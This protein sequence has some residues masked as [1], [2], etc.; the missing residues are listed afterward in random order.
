MPKTKND[1]LLSQ[2]FS[3][4]VMPVQF[5]SCNKEDDDEPNDT[6]YY[7]FSIVWDVVDK[8]DL[9]T[10]QAKNI[11]ASLTEDCEDIFEACTEAYAKNEFLDF[12]EQLR[13]EFSSEFDMFTVTLK[14]TLVR[15]EGNKT[16]AS[17]TFYIK[18]DGTIL[19]APAHKTGNKVSD[20]RIPD[21]KK[22]INSKK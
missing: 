3:L 6:A 10:A 17:K 13:Y 19:K 4:L 11:S 2:L 20:I 21:V 14:A 8:G 1:K 18:P 5:S 7:D 12:C 9:T 22:L 16:I 15:N